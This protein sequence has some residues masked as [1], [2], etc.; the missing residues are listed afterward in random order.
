MSFPKIVAIT[1]VFCFLVF[2]GAIAGFFRVAV[3]DISIFSGAPEEG[4]VTE[5]NPYIVQGKRGSL[6]QAQDKYALL[7][8][9]AVASVE[10]TEGDLNEIF[11][12]SFLVSTPRE[13]ATTTPSKTLGSGSSNGKKPITMLAQTL[14]VKFLPEGRVQLCISLDVKTELVKK[15]IPCTAIGYFVDKDFRVESFKVGAAEIYAGSGVSFDFFVSQYAKT[16][17]FESLSAIWEHIKSVRTA[18]DKLVVI[19][20]AA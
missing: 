19:F 3:M 17:Q 10:L 2:L 11:A 4:A 15:Q 12:S 1:L 9:H 20:A 5:G 7:K 6:T 14:N 13:V 8:S 18:N 16:P